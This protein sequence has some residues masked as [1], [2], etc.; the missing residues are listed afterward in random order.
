MRLFAW[1]VI[2]ISLPLPPQISQIECYPV[3]RV[4]GHVAWFCELKSS[5]FHTSEQPKRCYS[6][7]PRNSSKIQPDKLDQN[8]SPLLARLP[9]LSNP[10]FSRFCPSLARLNINNSPSLD[11]YF[12]GT[13]LPSYVICDKISNFEHPV[14]APAP[15]KGFFGRFWTFPWLQV[16]PTAQFWKNEKT[17]LKKI[18]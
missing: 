14:S 16:D 12:V 17:C 5:A 6:P 9:E 13:H 18:L 15:K 11:Y 3:E 10:N 8:R 1:T 2:W 7:E 4:W